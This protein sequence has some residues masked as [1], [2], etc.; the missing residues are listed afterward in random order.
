MYNV[1][2]HATKADTIGDNLLI[3]ALG[4]INQRGY[5]SGTA[6]TSANQYTLDRWRVVTSGQALTFSTSEN[7]A[8]LTLPTGGIE[9]VIEG[10]SIQS[11]THVISFTATGDTVCTV[12]GGTVVSGDTFTLTG[13]TN[14]TVKFSSASGTGTVKLPKVEEGSTAT[15]FSTA[16]TNYIAE[17]LLCE[18]YYQR[19]GWGAILFAVSANSVRYAYTFKTE[20]RVAP[21][22]AMLHTSPR[23]NDGSNNFTAS[24]PTITANTNTKG[25]KFATVTGFSGL[26]AGTPYHHNDASDIDFLEYSAEL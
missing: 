13:G 10:K 11:G 14:A 23:V 16:G 6:T 1:F 24:S 17:Y 12:D 20:M 8:T 2:G 7:V 5:I 22:V 9:Q 26:T 19:Y 4:T 15:P 3:N 21:T 25:L 18:R